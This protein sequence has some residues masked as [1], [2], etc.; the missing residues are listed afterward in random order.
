MADENESENLEQSVDDAAEAVAVQTHEL[1]ELAVDPE[2]GEPIGLD[3]LLEVPVRVTVQIGPWTSADGGVSASAAEVALA[4]LPATPR[5]WSG[6]L[7]PISGS[8]PSFHAS[9]RNLYRLRSRAR[10]PVPPARS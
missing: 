10:G 4:S 3:S 6:H 2:S 1:D 9:G 7:R 8:D 5:G